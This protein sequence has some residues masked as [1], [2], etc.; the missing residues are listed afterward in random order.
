M[1][2]PISSATPPPVQ[3]ASTSSPT[4][5]SHQRWGDALS[6]ALSQI[7]AFFKNLIQR[8]EGLDESRVAVSNAAPGSLVARIQEWVTKTF[9]KC[10]SIAH[11]H[12]TSQLGAST[13]N[14]STRDDITTLSDDRSLPLNPNVIN[15]GAIGAQQT[16]NGNGDGLNILVHEEID[17]S[18]GA[19]P[20]RLA[21]LERIKTEAAQI[22][23]QTAGATQMLL[24]G[25]VTKIRAA[26]PEA[27]LTISAELARSEGRYQPQAYQL[28][29]KEAAYYKSGV[30]YTLSVQI[31][32]KTHSFAPIQR[33]IFTTATEPPLAL[34]TA[35]KYAETVSALALGNPLLG[36]LE[37]SA[38][39]N[40]MK[41][42][43]FQF[44]FARDAAGR[45]ARL[46]KVIAQG[47]ALTWQATDPTEKKYVYVYDY[48]TGKLERLSTPA[49]PTNGRKTFASEEEAIRYMRHE[50]H[51]PRLFEL[52]AA[53]ASSGLAS[54]LEA[55][56]GKI[57]KIRTELA[58]H[59][60]GFYDEPLF[61]FFRKQGQEKAAFR[62]FIQG[63]RHQQGDQT[64]E[65]GVSAAMQQF[66]AKQ[67]ALKEAQAALERTTTAPSASPTPPSLPPQQLQVLQSEVEQAKKAVE[68]EQ[69]HFNELFSA[70][71]RS[72]QEL[73]NQLARL[74]AMM[75][76]AKTAAAQSDGSEASAAF[77]AAF[78]E[79][80]MAE[81]KAQVQA[82]HA[83][84]QGVLQRL[85]VMQVSATAQHTAVTAGD[86]TPTEPTESAE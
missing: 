60:A 74:E 78:P 41:Q 20:N 9:N 36:G 43:S 4:V 58:A 32:D 10:T 69:A 38:R 8:D 79:K 53:Q 16:N 1:N 66:L 18:Q 28:P 19:E 40:I 56:T 44:S 59:K 33:E 57:E 75:A 30:A 47:K 35:L 29:K 24:E 31:G 5:G 45:P 73:D 65:E 14:V 22:S 17:P 26:Y 70:F 85:E 49:T 81:L 61:K 72:N 21:A 12:P 51:N 13:S 64:A 67:R 76:Q 42:S 34:L 23:P 6:P 52:W 55:E 77:L 84:V 50:V 54:L 46:E 2:S 27:P 25:L 62:A 68:A 7:G 37:E 80:R 63:K 3:G 71:E 48:S 86:H 82:N 39:P 11:P 83:V 15:E